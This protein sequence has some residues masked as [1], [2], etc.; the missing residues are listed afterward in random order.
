[1]NLSIYKKNAAMI[2][3]KP[4]EALARTIVA[5]LLV[6]W[7]EV[8]AVELEDG[9]LAE[10]ALDPELEPDTEDPELELEL[11]PESDELELDPEPLDVL[12]DDDDPPSTLPGALLAD[13]VAA[14]AL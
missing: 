9:L 11:D 14:A 1:M 7:G 5:G 3:T 4:N 13:T 10:L 12:L 8:D 6:I 2:A